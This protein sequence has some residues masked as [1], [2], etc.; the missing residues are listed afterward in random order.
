MSSFII[1]LNVDFEEVFNELHPYDRGKFIEEH[2]EEATMDKLLDTI[3]KL[4]DIDAVIEWLDDKGY[5]V[6]KTE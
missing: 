1:S 6:T 2:L 4:G 5:S 3:D